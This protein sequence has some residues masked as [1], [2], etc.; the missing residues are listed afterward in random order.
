MA[1]QQTADN[2]WM[3]LSFGENSGTRTPLQVRCVFVPR[4]A[5]AISGPMQSSCWF[6]YVRIQCVWMVL[7]LFSERRK[8]FSGL[9][10][11]HKWIFYPRTFVGVR[12][13]L[14]WGRNFWVIPRVTW[15]VWIYS[16]KSRPWTVRAVC[17][18][19]HVTQCLQDRYLLISMLHVMAVCWSC[20]I[21]SILVR[22]LFWLWPFVCATTSWITWRRCNG[23]KSG[24][25]R[26]KV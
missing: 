13:L 11:M 8:T 16:C 20:W 9:M 19:P 17:V 2:L 21:Q 26:G 24:S 15:P 1:V 22:F 4:S 5:A 7:R 14:G 18:D 6:L 10:P 3:C 23:L 12:G 25:W